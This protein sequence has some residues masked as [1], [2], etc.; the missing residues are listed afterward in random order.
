MK[1]LDADQPG[2]A[3]ANSSG[4]PLGGLIMA[5]M[6][7]FGA[8]NTGL[9]GPNRTAIEREYGLDHAGF[10]LALAVIQI[11]CAAMLLGIAAS[12]RRFSSATGFV[13]ALGAQA[14]GFALIWGSRG[15]AAL[16]IGWTLITLGTLLGA[17]ANNLTSSLW[18]HNPRRGVNLLHGWNGVGKVCGPPVAALL[19]ASGWRTSFGVVG[20]VVLGLWGAFLFHK[21]RFDA[22]E[23]R[24]EKRA[25]SDA[26]AL[27][28]QPFYWACVLPFGLIAGGDVA[29]A[30]LAPLFYEKRWG[31]APETGSWLLT[32]HL[33]G[34]AVGRFTFV[35]LG[36]K[37]SP[38]AVIGACLI[39]GVCVFPAA[40]SPSPWV[41]GASLF[42]L[43]WMFSA[44]WPTF[45]AQVARFFPGREQMLALGSAL[46]NTL[47]IALCVWLSS[48]LADH[49]LVA[50]LGV[51]PLAVWVFGALYFAS[52]LSAKHPSSDTP[53]SS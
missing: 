13:A 16:G 45:Y 38:N 53:Q 1:T 35:A 21:P 2:G 8:V 41:W 47:G 46:G 36:E 30:T 49:N 31:L 10:G 32:L 50:A 34:V 7:L 51:G 48:A 42:G 28:K 23:P 4:A 15:V 11:V 40:L 25:A 6:W 39:T 19:L 29:F 17:V 14:L 37:W 44:V 5:W 27:L 24:A 52:P 18:A 20:I 26:M 9:I 22:L 3:P 12:R 43:G 33:M